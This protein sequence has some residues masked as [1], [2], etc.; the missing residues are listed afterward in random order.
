MKLKETKRSS[1]PMST[2]N[3]KTFRSGE[4][5]L[6]RI[7]RRFLSTIR[8]LLWAA[9]GAW[10]TFAIYYSNLPSGSMRLTLAVGFAAFGIWAF[11]IKRTPKVR[12]VYAGILLGVL[13]WFIAIPPKMSR[14]WRKE[15]A[16]MPRAVINGDKVTL[17]GFRNFEYQSRDHFT[18]HYEE[19]IVSLDDLTSVDLFIS[20]WSVGPIGHTFLSFNFDNAPPVCISIETRPEVGEGFSPIASAFKEY[21]LFYAVGD[22]RDLVGVRT[23]H[24]NEEVY[25]YR[26]NLPP[27]AVRRLFLVYLERINE[28][29]DRAEW[30]YLFRQNCTLNIVR[31]KNAAGREGSFDIRHLL[32][33]WIDRYFYETEMVDTSMPFEE[34]RKTSKINEAAKSA[35]PSLDAMEFSRRIREGLPGHGKQSV[36][37]IKK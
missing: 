8:V 2:E 23:N 20:Y 4:P 1:S 25:L 21:E 19:R 31:Y 9:A 26:M 18:E 29:A 3:S 36:E 12:L 6:F 28:L 30:Y 17:T 24:R 13:A 14:E 34:L 15:V 27:E 16:I 35:D 5:V 11:L 7:F 10:G 22:E 37:P 32:N 33:G